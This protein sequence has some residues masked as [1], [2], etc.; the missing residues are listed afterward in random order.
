[1]GKLFGNSCSKAMDDSL[2]QQNG[3]YLFSIFPSRHFWSITINDHPASFSKFYPHS[4]LCKWPLLVQLPI[5]SLEW[6]LLTLHWILS[7]STSK[8]GLLLRV[9]TSAFSFCPSAPLSLNLVTH[10]NFKTTQ[11]QDKGKMGE[12]NFKGCQ[13]LSN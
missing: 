8:W 10:G 9:S 2:H 3:Y 1:M 11:D 7:S 12:T 5:C 4:K 6:P 13:K